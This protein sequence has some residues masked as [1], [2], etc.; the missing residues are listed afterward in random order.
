[1]MYIFRVRASFVYGPKFENA[2]MKNERPRGGRREICN[3]ERVFSFGVERGEEGIYY[4]REIAV[5]TA[6]EIIEL[7]RCLQVTNLKC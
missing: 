5:E 3:R 4:K 7:C 1:M 2:R 6:I